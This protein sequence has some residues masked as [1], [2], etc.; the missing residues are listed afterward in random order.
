MGEEKEKKKKVKEKETEKGEGRAPADL[1]PLAITVFT[2]G[3]DQKV[4]SQL[5]PGRHLIRQGRLH[6]RYQIFYRMAI[7]CH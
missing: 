2:G 1:H 4:T 3:A 7:V 5:L 6:Q